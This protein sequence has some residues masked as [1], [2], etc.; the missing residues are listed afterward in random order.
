MFSHSIAGARRR[1]ALTLAR[2]LALSTA[3]SFAAH[4]SAAADAAPACATDAQTLTLQKTLDGPALQAEFDAAPL[5]GRRV[6]IAAIGRDGRATPLRVS[7]TLAFD[8][9]PDGR[10]VLFN[11]AANLFVAPHADGYVMLSA[12]VEPGAHRINV[13]A[14][15]SADTD[16]SDV[17][18]RLQCSDEPVP[19][20]AASTQQPLLDEALKLYFANVAHAP[21]DP[22]R[23]RALAQSRA[24]GAEVP[25]DVM[26]ALR[27]MLYAAGDAHSY[28]VLRSSRGAFFDMLAPTPPRVEL[29]DDGVALVALSQVAFDNDPAAENAYAR[30][31]HAAIARVE[32]R[33][34]RGWIVDLREDGGGSMWPMLAGLS[35]LVGGPKVGAFVSREVVDPWLVADGQ[36][37]TG[38][39]P[40]QATVGPH[41]PLAIASPVAVLIG[42]DT[43]SSGES[44]AIA[45]EQRPHTRFFGKPTLGLYN[46]G[47]SQYSLSDGTM[48]GIV[49]VLN[50]DRTG[51]V[52]EGAL[53]PDA[54]IADGTDAV[55]AAAAWVISE[56]SRSA[57]APA[58]PSKD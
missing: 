31:L 48:F 51:R 8:R 50:A 19:E 18:L 42:P 34:P 15:P 14:T 27:D 45:F 44:T 20:G 37:G 52:R 9:T 46:S 17:T 35:P 53:V 6:W 47:V 7:L 43:A 22:A 49:H 25:D 2:A 32:A 58:A 16:M 4:A 41:E 21:S 39:V 29:R 3:L 33:H 28:L 1:V 26:W 5:R 36:A 56:S 40:V 23:L 30:D 10:S 55:A 24:T 13:R 57:P 54:V 38:S 11:Q 12:W